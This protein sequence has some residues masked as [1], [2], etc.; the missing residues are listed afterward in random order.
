MRAAHTE[1]V[2][3]T[4]KSSN[5]LGES[6]TFGVET[7]KAVKKQLIQAALHYEAHHEEWFKD[8]I[9]SV[10]AS[11]HA[12]SGKVKSGAKQLFHIAN[13]TAFYEKQKAASPKKKRRSTGS[14]N[15]A[16][17]KKRSSSA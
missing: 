4:N 3:K 17:P 15:P 11:K 2:T 6:T 5:T 12:G 14:P 1:M 9:K 7:R 16:S 13:F 8:E 10:G